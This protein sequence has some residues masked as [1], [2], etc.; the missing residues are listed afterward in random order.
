MNRIAPNTNRRLH[1]LLTKVNWL[2][3]P[4]MKEQLVEKYSQIGSQSSR[5]LLETEARQLVKHLEQVAE[6]M[7]KMRKKLLSLGYQMHWDRPDC[8]ELQGL[9][10]YMVNKLR[11]DRWCKSD[12]SRHRKG[13]AEMTAKELSETITQLEKVLQKQTA[14]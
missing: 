2:D 8:P 5:D 14:L 6:R 10:P 7:D 9:E 11:V 4:G 3:K 13:I 12:K 1:A